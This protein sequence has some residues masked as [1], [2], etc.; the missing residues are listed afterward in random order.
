MGVLGPLRYRDSLP[1]KSMRAI[2]EK[3]DMPVIYKAMADCRRRLE[4]I[5]IDLP[6][7][8][9]VIANEDRRAEG[10]RCR[11]PI[12]APAWPAFAIASLD[13]YHMLL[14]AAGAPERH[15][16]PFAPFHAA[17]NR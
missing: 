17:Q 7:I 15:S 9:A 8:F 14:I 16:A 3:L 4:T 2:T 6:G 12:V 13:V 11:I 5:F 10:R 1:S